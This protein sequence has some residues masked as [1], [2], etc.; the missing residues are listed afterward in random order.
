MPCQ[1]SFMHCS[2]RSCRGS[3]AWLDSE[4]APLMLMLIV[5]CLFVL[6]L[7]FVA[8]CTRT[9]LVSETSPVRI[10]PE[11]QG[12]VYVKTDEGWKLGDNAVKIPEGWYC[13]PP[14]YVEN[15]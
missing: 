3:K 12:R 4:T 5:V 2:R 10:G 15:E 8:G 7:A 11:M 6:A 1:A 14:S 13:V 9:V